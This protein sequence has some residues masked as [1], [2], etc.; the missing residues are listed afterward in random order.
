MGSC[1]H[2][3]DAWDI[4]LINFDF[5]LPAVNMECTFK[6][7]FSCTRKEIPDHLL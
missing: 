1:G 6:I 2:S 5:K 7:D 3:W 4:E